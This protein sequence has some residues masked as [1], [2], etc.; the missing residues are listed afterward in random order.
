MPQLHTLSSNDW[1][2]GT[3]AILSATLRSV[4]TSDN[5]HAQ[6]DFPLSPCADNFHLVADFDRLHTQRSLLVEMTT[7]LVDELTALGD[8]WVNRAELWENVRAEEQKAIETAVRAEL[9][10]RIDLWREGL[11]VGL[12]SLAVD[13]TF[14]FLIDN[15]QAEGE[16]E[17]LKEGWCQEALKELQAAAHHQVER[18]LREWRETELAD[19]WEV[20]MAQVSLEDVIRLCGNDGAAVIREG[21]KCMVHYITAHHQKWVDDE[22]DR[23]HPDIEELAMKTTREEHLRNERDRVYLD[24]HAEVREA[25]A[26]YCA[27]LLALAEK[28]IREEVAEERHLALLKAAA[29]PKAAK[30]AGKAKARP[31]SPMDTKE[32]PAETPTTPQAP[33]TKAVGMAVLATYGSEAS[34]SQT[35]VHGPPAAPAHAPIMVEPLQ[36]NP[37]VAPLHGLG[38]SV[39][40]PANAM[41]DDPPEML[42]PLATAVTS[43]ASRIDAMEGQTVESRPPVPA[44]VPTPPLAAPVK[45]A[46]PPKKVVAPMTATNPP[47]HEKVG[48]PPLVQAMPHPPKP[49][50]PPPVPDAA[51]PFLAKSA[52]PRKLAEPSPQKAPATPKATPSPA[53]LAGDYIHVGQCGRPTYLVATKKGIAQHESTTAKA[54]AVAAAQGCTLAGTLSRQAPPSSPAKANTTK[55]IIVRHGGF[56]DKEKEKKLC[57]GNLGNLV[58]G[59]RTAIAQKMAKPIRLLYGHWSREADRTGNF[60]YMIAGKLTMSQILPYQEFLCAPFPGASLVPA[61][62]WFWAQLRGVITHNDDG[63]LCSED[64]LEAELR[65]HPTFETVPFIVKPHWLTHP[66]NIREAT[67]TIGFTMEDPTGAVIQAALAGPVSMFSYQVKFVPCGDSPSLIQCGHCHAIGHRTNDKACKWRANQIRCQCCGRDHHI[68]DHNFECLNQ[69]VV[70]GVCKCKY[71][72]LLCGEQGHDA[73]SHKC[74]KRG[75]FPPMKLA[76]VAGRTVAPPALPREAAPAVHINDEVEARDPDPTDEELACACAEHDKATAHIDSYVDWGAEPRMGGWGD[77]DMSPAALAASAAFHTG[78]LTSTIPARH[79]TR[80]MDTAKPSKSSTDRAIACGTAIHTA[81]LAP[82]PAPAYDPSSLQVPALANP[83]WITAEM[84]VYTADRVARI[85]AEDLNGV[86]RVWVEGAQWEMDHDEIN[87]EFFAVRTKE[88]RFLCHVL[89]ED[90]SVLVDGDLPSDEDIAAAA[91]T[92]HPF[93]LVDWLGTRYATPGLRTARQVQV[94][95]L[96]ITFPYA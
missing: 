20:A 6:G 92:C 18:E 34:T 37:E 69:H 72:C 65:L 44:A 4:L 85:D 54:K 51:F 57:F 73:H 30:K 11:W 62:G 68:D 16:L 14:K 79:V 12:H 23:I 61:E 19:A 53:D 47:P 91:L 70:L 29:A 13:D 43:L 93:S 81:K 42:C 46:A 10:P 5:F 67:A 48:P 86:V 49:V 50:R 87:N 82:A 64:E 7:Q 58:M 95:D 39:H 38:S 17:A 80:S 71:K 9:A 77:D 45:K 24:V 60:I 52:L 27:T 22:L 3:L 94:P 26:K 90:H 31:P 28:K 76:K 21:K 25:V 36:L 8:T 2:R 96:D 84:L 75:D 66:A 1:Y 55:V 15:L 63:A 40:C 89:K 74:P 32:D 59:V 78:K 35:T 33:A 88:A 41:E 83:P 56:A